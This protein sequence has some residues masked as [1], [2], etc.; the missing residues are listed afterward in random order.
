MALMWRQARCRFCYG[1]L[2]ALIFVR[3]LLI[4]WR[5]GILIWMGS[6]SVGVVP[7][8]EVGDLGFVVSSDGVRGIGGKASGNDVHA[9][10]LY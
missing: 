2:E 8:F 7:L 6:D 9:L 1:S 4:L 3:N 10:L 5:R